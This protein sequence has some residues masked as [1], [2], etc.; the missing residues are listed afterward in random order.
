VG[1]IGIGEWLVWLVIV[2]AMLAVGVAVVRIGFR[3]TSRDGSRRM[4]RERLARGEITQAEFEQ[5]HRS[6]GS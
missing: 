5:A 2:T 6:L 1:G 3:M 4:L